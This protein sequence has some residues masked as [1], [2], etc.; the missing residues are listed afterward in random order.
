MKGIRLTVII[1]V[2]ALAP[3]AL[4]A[5]GSS[6]SSSTS[7]ADESEISNAI[8][9]SATS[10]EASACTEFQTQKFTEQTSGGTGAAAVKSCEQSAADSPSDSVVVTNIQVD[11]DTATA[12]A[13]LTGGFI[14]GQTLEIALAKDGDQWKVDQL[15]GFAD[16]NREAF[17]SSI[18]KQVAED[19]STSAQTA[20]CLQQQFDKASDQEL[21]DVF[22]NPDGGAKFFG[23]CFQAQ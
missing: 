9:Q 22:L 6:D 8:T 21:E 5:C 16:F 11:G 2:M 3:V 23:P 12:D 17:I 4:A 19:P 10:G 18:L 14:D 1:A 13:A 15:T 7:S 20:T